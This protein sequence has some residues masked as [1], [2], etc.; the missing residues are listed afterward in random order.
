M[1]R[2]IE[3]RSPGG[4][5][6][7]LEKLLQNISLEDY[8][9]YASEIDVLQNEDEKTNTLI[10]PTHMTGDK[11]KSILSKSEYL[12][13]FINLQAYPI[14]A[15]TRNIMVYEDFLNSS[16]EIIILIADVT[17]VEIYVKEREMM[18]CFIKNA[19]RSGCTNISIKTDLNDGRTKLSVQ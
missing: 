11:L 3:F 15:R 8:E 2:G 16:C 1:M 19:E 18:C 12:I 14:G 7:I 9:W 6:K 10:F 5:S 17:F 4:Y 13:N